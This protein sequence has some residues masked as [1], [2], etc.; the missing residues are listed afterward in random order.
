MYKKFIT[1]LKLNKPKKFFVVFIEVNFKRKKNLLK[2]IIN[3][4]KFKY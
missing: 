3:K 1:N 2:V 4:K